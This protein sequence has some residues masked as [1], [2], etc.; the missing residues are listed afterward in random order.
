MESMGAEVVDRLKS[1]RVTHV[2]YRD[3]SYETF[4]RARILKAKLVSVLWIEACRKKG[5][6]VNEAKYPAL[7]M[8][9][10]DFDLTDVCGRL[11][12]DDVSILT[13]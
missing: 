9:V 11:Q 10:P 7:G 1:R 5:R 4:Q 8:N 6:R 2:V 3:G 13:T 12:F